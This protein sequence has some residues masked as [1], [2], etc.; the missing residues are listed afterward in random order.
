ML[1]KSKKQKAS[2]FLR[3]FLLLVII[4]L[5]C[6]S[7]VSQKLGGTIEEKTGTI[8]NSNIQYYRYQNSFPNEQLVYHIVTVPL[9]D[10]CLEIVATP[11]QSNIVSGQTTL[12]FAQEN[13]LLLALN[14]TPFSYSNGILSATRTIVGLYV[15]EGKEY[16]AGIEKYAALCFTKDNKAFIVNSQLDPLISDAWYA[17]GG[18]WTILE[19]NTIIQFKEI[20]DARTAV[21]IN[22]NGTELY[23]LTVEKNSKSLGLNYMD[24][25]KILQDC[26]ATKAIQ[27]D[28]GGSTSL[29]IGKNK[30]SSVVSNRKV[31]ISF[32]IKN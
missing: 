21:G 17:F 28:G 13:N 27:L 10:P 15:N 2:D 14:A 31:A 9:D 18:F 1:T 7:C 6:L 22:P 20:K 30:S 16:S 8:S 24:C 19:N 5:L 26:G 23:I 29:I 3:L 11:V 32:G 25:A 4:P 12:K